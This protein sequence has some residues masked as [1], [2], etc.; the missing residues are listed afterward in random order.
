MNPKVKHAEKYTEEELAE[1]LAQKQ[2]EK[3][4]ELRIRHER[5]EEKEKNTSGNR[6]LFGE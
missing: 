4:R 1:L 5:E 3:E 2:E 6:N